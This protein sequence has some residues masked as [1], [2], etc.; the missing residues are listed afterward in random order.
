MSRAKNIYTIFEKVKKGEFKSYYKESGGLFGKIDFYKKPDLIKPHL[1]YL[2][3]DR[4]KSIMD[5]H[6]TNPD[7]IS[8]SYKQYCSKVKSDQRL[9]SDDYKR[10]FSEYYQTKFPKHLTRDIFKMYYNKINDLE[11]EERSDKNHTQFKIL[12]KSN[13]PVS[14]IMSESSQLKSAV[15]TR[16]MVEHFINKLLYLEITN[17]N[18]GSDLTK[19]LSESSEFDSKDTDKMLKD[20]FE[21]SAAKKDLEQAIDK[22]TETCKAL[23]QTMD[24]EQQQQMFEACSNSEA[25]KL[26]VNYLNTVKTQLERVNMSMGALKNK[27]KN[28][29]NKSVS[30]FSAKTKVKFEDIFNSDSVVDIQDEYLLHPRLRKL[31]AEDL[32]VKDT[33]SVGKI[34]V[35]LDISGSMDSSAGVKNEQNHEISKAEFGKALIFKMKQMDILNDFYTFNTSVK[36]HKSDPISIA[37][38]NTNGGTSINNVIKKVNA[39]RVN[40]LII[41]DAEDHCSEYSDHAFFIGVKGCSFSHFHAPVIAEYAEKDQLIIFEGDQIV[42]VDKDGNGIY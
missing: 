32:M 6:F 3:Q 34:D 20:L 24:A 8:Q 33:E 21:S 31:F 27:I 14:K 22:A 23:D 38:I 30:Y 36:L 25:S 2:D 29:L 42:R 10:K 15:F 11:F 28:L 9:G 26:D 12:E 41:T 40:A 18:Q 13:H 35:Y 5:Q 16:T 17:P 39:N 4:L 7:T 19:S 37:M 1:H